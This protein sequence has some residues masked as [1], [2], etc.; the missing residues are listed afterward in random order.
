MSED[1]LYGNDQTPHAGGFRYAIVAA[2]FNAFIVDRLLDAALETLKAGGASSERIDV[3][4]VPGAFEIPLAC[5]KVART[6]RFDAIIA[7]G[8]V[9][10]G[11]TP[12]FDYVCSE[13]ARGIS[14]VALKLDIPVINGIL[15]TDNPAQAQARVDTA[16]G[17][18]KGS[19]AAK[20]AMEVLSVYAGLESASAGKG[21]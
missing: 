20:A 13:S 2:R 11:D 18:N 21:R 6:G 14:E 10:R 15:T 19:D 8:C 4:R 9:I 16:S 17:N 5:Q 12:H 3:Y 1:K 7:L